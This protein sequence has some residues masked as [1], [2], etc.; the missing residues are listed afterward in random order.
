MGKFFV[1]VCAY[2]AG[3]DHARRGF[4][5]HDNIPRLGWIFC[6]VNLLEV[7]LDSL[8]FYSVDGVLQ[9]F[10]VCELYRRWSRG[11][12]QNISLVSLTGFFGNSFS[13]KSTV[14]AA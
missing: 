4:C 11:K 14:P 8:Q 13:Q 12:A 10:V 7:L 6:S 2:E 3:L 9:G 1:L 5:V